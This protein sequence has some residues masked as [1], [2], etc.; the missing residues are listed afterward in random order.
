MTLLTLRN[1]ASIWWLNDSVLMAEYVSPWPLGIHLWGP[2][3]V[4]RILSRVRPALMRIYQSNNDPHTSTWKSIKFS[5]ER[6]SVIT[7]RRMQLPLQAQLLLPL[8]LVRC[9][10]SPSLVIENACADV[11]LPL[12]RRVHTN[13]IK[14]VPIR[15][16]Q[17]CAITWGS[18]A[19]CR[20]FDT[21]PWRFCIRCH[22]WCDFAGISTWWGR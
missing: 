18:S 7:S 10:I 21:W 6:S 12:H 22:C 13:P 5:S 16:I 15:W 9:S 17:Q 14:N 4:P 8:L 2:L 1:K 11:N 20:C 3:C 19:K